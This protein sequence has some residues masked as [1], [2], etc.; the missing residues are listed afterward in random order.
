MPITGSLDTILAR[1]ASLIAE[2]SDAWLEVVITG[3]AVTGHL[4]DQLDTA[5]LGSTLDV[6]RIKYQRGRVLVMDN[7]ADDET[8]DDLEPDDVFRRRLDAG[9][10]PDEER[11]ELMASYQQVIQDLHEQDPHLD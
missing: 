8:L 6:L 11:A 7:L 10:V 2:Q 5:L 4:R 3:H 1:I 9:A